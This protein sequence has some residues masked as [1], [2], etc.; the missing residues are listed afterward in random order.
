MAGRRCPATTEADGRRRACPRILT[1]GERYCTEHAREYEAKRGTRAARGYGAEHARLRARVQ[2]R[3]DD[4]Q[5]VRCVTCNVQLHGRAWDLGH[6][7]DRA[8]YRGPQC[9][10][11]NRS[12]GGSRG[13]TVAN[14]THD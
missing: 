5:T 9:Q 4:G 13:A 7:E 3:I 12:D 10:P 8:A 14:G 6:T 2:D 11:C 1:R